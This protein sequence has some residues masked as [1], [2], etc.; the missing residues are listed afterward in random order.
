MLKSWAVLNYKKLSLPSDIIWYNS[1]IR[2][3]NKPF[4]W[5]KCYKNGLLYVSQLYVNNNPISF[6]E[7]ETLYALSFLDYHAILAAIPKET[8]TFLTGQSVAAATTDLYSVIKKQAKPT[9]YAY[10]NLIINRTMLG[11]KCEKWEEEL[12]CD[13]L[14]SDYADTF[15]RIK[16]ITKIAKFRSFQYQLN[17]RALVTN[18]HLHKWK[19]RDSELCSFC[20]QY[21]ETLSHLFVFCEK[22]Q[23][24]WLQFEN[25]VKLFNSDEMD[26]STTNILWSCLVHKKGHVINFMS[27]VLKQYIYRQRCMKSPLNFCEFK[28]LLYKIRNVEKY[29]AMKEN[30][31]KAFESKWNKTEASRIENTQ[32]FNAHTYIQTYLGNIPDT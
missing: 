1:N 28:Q 25:F 21:K 17:H 20:G 11:K 5:K 12:D 9:A 31:L 18:C 2:I 24:L 23:P 3:N 30:T 22:I 27:L 16:A 26:I 8:K 7:A 32:G 19:L 15:Q 10:N 13:I 6:Q 29:E 4:F 14:F